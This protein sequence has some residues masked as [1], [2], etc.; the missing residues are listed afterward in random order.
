MSSS[1]RTKTGPDTI[2][3]RRGS[4]GLR[5][6]RHRYPPNRQARQSCLLILCA[7]CDCCLRVVRLPPPS[8]LLR[9]RAPDYSDNLRDLADR[10]RAARTVMRQYDTV[11]T[12]LLTV[13][14]SASHTM[15]A[16]IALVATKSFGVGRG[17]AV[18]VTVFA[19]MLGLTVLGGHLRA[20]WQRKRTDKRS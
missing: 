9:G 6:G 17:F 14:T 16:H 15:D 20:S 4:G 12:P 2:D 13:A 19:L 18:L 8:H 3:E 10:C 7:N 5:T 11:L 1:R